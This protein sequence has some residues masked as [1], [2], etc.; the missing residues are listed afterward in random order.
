MTCENCGHE[1]Q[2]GDWPFC[3]GGHGRPR[4]SVIDDQI[5]GGPRVFETLGHDGVYIESKS[6]W[7]REVAARE[8]IVHYDAHDSAFYA[9]RKREHEERR[10]DLRLD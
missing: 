10:K 7:R 2:V 5:E 4:L 8:D 9:K 1:I 6:Q 3:H